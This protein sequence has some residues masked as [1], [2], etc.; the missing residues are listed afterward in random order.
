MSVPKLPPFDAKTFAR[1]LYER[2]RRPDGSA[3][4]AFGEDQFPRFID[5][6]RGQRDVVGSHDVQLA[7]HK[8]DIDVLRESQAKQFIESQKLAAR[9]GVLEAARPPFPASG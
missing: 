3:Y 8:S 2:V 1:R 9:V 6:L 5:G 4:L 7:D